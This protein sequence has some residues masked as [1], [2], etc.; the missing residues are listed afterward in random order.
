LTVFALIVTVRVTDSECWLQKTELAHEHH[1]FRG[2][3]YEWPKNLFRSGF[4][5]PPSALF[6]RPGH[7][8]QLSPPP[9][10]VFEGDLAKADDVAA[11]VRGQSAVVSA[12]GPQ[13]DV[14]ALLPIYETLAAGLTKAGVRR[15]LVVGGAGSLELAPGKALYDSPAV[16]QGGA[17]YRQGAR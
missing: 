2:Y 15:L 3:W 11:A 6:V 14:N 10:R 13:G 9:A 5:R 17:S 12:L 8:I 4:P 16:P 1:P 7:E